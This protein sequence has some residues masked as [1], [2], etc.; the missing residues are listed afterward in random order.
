MAPTTAAPTTAAPTP[1]PTVCVSFAYSIATENG[2]GGDTDTAEDDITER[3]LAATE[4]I[5]VA[6]NEFA[7]T[8]LAID[9]ISE[10]TTDCTA[11]G[12]C[13]IVASTACV[14]DNNSND[15]TRAALL[16]TLRQ[17]VDGGSFQAA[18][19]ASV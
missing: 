13:W 10:T 8:S 3:L 1:L 19:P 11:S 6:N 15:D 4:A 7:V 16:E 18:I 14:W 12:R 5:L 2:G 17:A 9:R